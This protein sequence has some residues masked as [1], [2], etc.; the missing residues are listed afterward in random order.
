L[1]RLNLSDCCLEEVPPCLAAL[2]GSLTS[3]TLSCNVNLGGEDNDVQVRLSPFTC[4][5]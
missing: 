3:L 4:L 5:L 1:Q 2:A